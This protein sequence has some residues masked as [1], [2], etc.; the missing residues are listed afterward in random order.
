MWFS[1]GTLHLFVLSLLANS[2][3]SSFI[4]TSKDNFLHQGYTFKARGRQLDPHAALLPFFV[5]TSVKEV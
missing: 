4:H 2:V 1:N 5:D 3:T